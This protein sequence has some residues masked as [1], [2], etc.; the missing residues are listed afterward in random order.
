MPKKKHDKPKGRG[1][2]ETPDNVTPFSIKPPAWFAEPEE[3][4]ENWEEDD[5][6]EE[7]FPG[8]VHPYTM[9]RS[10]RLLDDYIR[11]VAGDKPVLNEEFLDSMLMSPDFQ[12]QLYGKMPDSPQLMAAELAS[13][14]HFMED[15]LLCNMLLHA[16]M[17]LDPENLSAAVEITARDTTISAEIRVERLQKLNL[18]MEEELDSLPLEKSRSPLLPVQHLRTYINVGH[19]LNG[20][21]VGLG[22]YDEAIVI[23]EK[24]LQRPDPDIGLFRPRLTGLYLAQNRVEEAKALLDI[25]DEDEMA[26]DW[27]W[28]RVLERFLAE[29]MAGAEKMYRI[30][31]KENPLI[32]DYLIGKIE[33]PQEEDEEY[34]TDE[35]HSLEEDADRYMSLSCIAWSAHPEAITWIEKI[36]KKRK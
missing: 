36:R 23:I 27:T 2:G 10:I 32:G 8:G 26:G 24:R 18:R 22:R 28:S 20:E 13:M 1:E 14:S 31:N 35:D 16:A 12:E 29:D 34:L 7:E 5:L 33:W 6:F 4:E 15:D 25:L 3:D 9:D 30:A 21:L 11:N 17:M 19:A